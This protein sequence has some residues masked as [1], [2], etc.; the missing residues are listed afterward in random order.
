MATGTN[1]ANSARQLVRDPNGIDLDDSFALSVF[2]LAL[3]QIHKTLLELESDLIR[4][5]TTITTVEDQAEYTLETAG[6]SEISA[7]GILRD[8]IWRDDFEVPLE[9]WIKSDLIAAGKDP[10]Q[11]G[12]PDKWYPTGLNSFGLHPVPDSSYAGKTYN[13]FYWQDFKSLTTIGSDVPYSGIFDN[14]LVYWLAQ[15]Y[16]RSIEDPQANYITVMLDELWVSALQRVYDYGVTRRR[17]ASDMFEID[18]I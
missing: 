16:L 10:T 6:G 7:A 3:R 11:E 18:G 17:Q 2:N 5:K 9:K 8:G 12:C 4:S 13:V 14:V 15:D 1:I